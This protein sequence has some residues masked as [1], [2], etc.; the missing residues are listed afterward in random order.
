MKH[1]FGPSMLAAAVVCG[2]SV[3]A[4]AD[5]ACSL[6][7]G[8]TRA[9]AVSPSHLTPDGFGALTP[10]QQ[11]SVCKTRAAIKQLGAQKDALLDATIKVTMSYSTKYLSPAE[12]TRID[13]AS[14]AWLLK[15][16]KAKGIGN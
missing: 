1:A 10:P 8:D 11:E 14:D 4:T 15:T 16:L 6:S 5:P 12:K 3:P 7:E 9:L 13:T 2:L